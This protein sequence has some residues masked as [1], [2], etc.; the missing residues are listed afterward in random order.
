MF[1]ITAAVVTSFLSHAIGS[2][3]DPSKPG[4]HRFCFSA[5]IQSSIAFI[6]PGYHVLCVSFELQS[7]QLVSGSL[8]MVYTTIFSLFL[9]FG[10]TIG[11]AIFGLIDKHAFSKIQCAPTL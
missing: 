3:F 1:E 5:L 6:L 7:H 2:I 9:G 8:R 10:T 11:T 4:G